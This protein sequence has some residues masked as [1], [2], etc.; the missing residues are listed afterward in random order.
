MPV[1]W[2]RG[3]RNSQYRSVAA[4]ST[5]DHVTS[6]LL[7][8]L[9]ASSPPRLPALLA[10]PLAAQ[11]AVHSAYGW[12]DGWMCSRHYSRL[13]TLLLRLTSARIEFSCAH[14][15]VGCKKFSSVFFSEIQDRVFHV[16]IRAP[17]SQAGL[18][19][20]DPVISRGASERR[21][22]SVTSLLSGL[23]VSV[24]S[25]FA[26]LR[27]LVLPRS[28]CFLRRPPASTSR[29]PLLARRAAAGSIQVQIVSGREW[30]GRC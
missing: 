19:P 10:A 21:E 17:S 26:R 23:A 7:Q 6:Q 27:S 15:R 9:R 25:C 2:P 29:I 28:R 30:R 22:F 14:A 20:S 12:L 16:P 13:H 5:P 24:R 3:G 1:A 11:L 4:V 18:C 8:C